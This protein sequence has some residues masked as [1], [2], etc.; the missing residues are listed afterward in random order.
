MTDI[1]II[2]LK[3]LLLVGLWVVLWFAHRLNCAFY[4]WRTA[5][6]I[7]LDKDT[8]WMVDK[9]HTLLYPPSPLGAIVGGVILSLGIMVLR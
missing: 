9:G 1:Q 6:W 4:R 7:P 8:V 2:A 5:G 3:A